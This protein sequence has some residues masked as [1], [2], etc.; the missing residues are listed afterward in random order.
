MSSEP[1]LVRCRECQALNRVPQER[2]SGRPLC[3]KCKAALEVP[4]E[5]MLVRA[6]NYDRTVANWPETLL[7]VFTAPLCVQCKIIE[8]LLNDLA[9][10]RAGRLK[11][12]KVDGELDP[13]LIQRFKVERTPTFILYKNASEVIRVDGLPKNRSDIATW[14]DNIIGYTNY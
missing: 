6:D 8:P 1:I 9:R 14:I 4:V 10:E 12:V 11:I 3:G 7:A 13:Y 2:L 5:P